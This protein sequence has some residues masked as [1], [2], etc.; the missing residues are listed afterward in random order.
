MVP[1]HTLHPL[2]DDMAF[3]LGAL[4]EP[5]S[6]AVHAVRRSQLRPGE[7]VTIIGAG[8]I[9]LLILSVCRVLSVPEQST[10]PTSTPDG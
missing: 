9:G 2:P 4:V 10:S 6:I 8:P 7:T 1:S 5:T 3:E